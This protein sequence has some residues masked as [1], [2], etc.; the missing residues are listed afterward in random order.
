MVKKF[1]NIILFLILFSNLF[2]QN[3]Q[4]PI[5]K[6]GVIDLR[7]WDFTTNGNVKLSGEW[8]FFWQKLYSPQ[9]FKNTV[10][11]PDA[12]A[13]VPGVWGNLKINDE[14][15]PDTGYA[16]YRIVIFI[17]KDSTD[18]EYMLRFYEILTNYKVWLNG[19]L[20]GQQGRV[21]TNS[22]NAQAAV[23]QVLIPVRFNN[24]RNELI[25]QISNYKHRSSGFDKAPV[26]G[27]TKSIIRAF[28]LS[29]AF[30]LILF[31]VMLIMAFYHLGL[32]ILRRKNK[33]ALSFGALTLVIGF[34]TLITSNYFLPYILPTLSWDFVYINNYITYYLLVPLLTLFFQIA[35]KIKKFKWV[36]NFIYIFSGIYLLT[37]FLLPSLIY[38]KILFIYQIFTLLVIIFSIYL[39]INA[40]KNKKHGAK[41]FL[42]SFLFLVVCGINDM[43]LYNNI[44]DSIVLMPLGV[45]VLILGQSLTLARIFTKAFT[46]NESLMARLDYQN[47]H[48]QELVDERTKEIEQQKQHILQKNEE[49]QM[50]KEELEVQRDEINRQKEILEEHNKFITDSI[51]YASSIQKAILPT[52][53]N[54][55][56]YFDNFVLF[57]PKDIVSGDFYWFSDVNPKYVF[58]ALGDCTGHGVP[59]A[60]LSLISM[61][62]LNVVIIEHKIEDPKEILTSFEVLFNEF[63]NKTHNDNR[64]GLDIGILRFSKNNLHDFVCA[65]AKTNIFIFNH[66]SEEMIRYKGTRKSIG[67]I[68]HSAI[69]SKF[70]FENLTL[71]L[72]KKVTIYI[73]S[74][75]YVDQNNKERKRFGTKRFMPLLNE[76]ANLPIQQQK[77]TLIKRLEEFQQSEPQRD[78]IS[79]VGLR[80]KN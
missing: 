28:V 32:F 31:G 48:L 33:A 51:N 19:E 36:F 54:M 42:F 3:E 46:D 49:L 26:I 21:G 8:E 38:T 35:F 34:R 56:K 62:L 41:L 39:V 5:A 78:D 22:N 59:G 63:L 1:L 76:I 52:G 17:N 50:Q 23:R 27:K 4:T 47:Q 67:N 37:V 80:P 15:I 79:V 44:I 40:W 61:Y 29:I 74:D 25:V 6:K 77:I 9:D 10:H 7:N 64:D 18:A 68:S 71:T 65:S 14:P 57:M 58:F 2:G 11:S 12:Y 70:K 55:K 53:E 45:F 30:D 43:L 24:E 66:E 72:P 20:V 13:T 60:F 73:A 16:T 75:G 69:Y